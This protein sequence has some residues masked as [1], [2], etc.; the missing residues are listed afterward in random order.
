MP[1]P[2]SIGVTNLAAENAADMR[3]SGLEFAI[4]YQGKSKKLNYS[5]GVSG[6]LFNVNEVTGLGNR[7]LETVTGTSIIRIGAPFNA[8]YGFQALGIFQT[9]AEVA[10]A[11]VQFGSLL[12]A[13]GDIRYADISGPAGKPDGIIDDN[14]LS[15]IGTPYPKMS[16]NINGTLNYQGLDLS[17]VLHGLSGINRFLNGNGQ[18][19]M[20][21]DVTNSLEYWIDRW[22]PSKPSTTLPRVGGINN[23]KISTF[24]LQDASY[25]RLKNIEIGYT[26]P[27]AKTKKF[28]ISKFRVYV[29]G[30]NLLTFTK[31][32]YYDPERANSTGTDQ[33]VPLYKVYT[34]GINLKF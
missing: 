20:N 21:D 34:A 30:Q 31:M 14:D 12:T 33:L 22:T 27:V 4:N 26:F 28:L 19:P 10:S 9:A 25:L 16:Y 3:N 5:I 15:V 6:S 29:S 13:P 1:V 8:Y 18:G 11:P 17:L 7:G 32:L 24:Y 2:A 23:T